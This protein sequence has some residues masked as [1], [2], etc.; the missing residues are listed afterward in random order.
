MPSMFEQQGENVLEW[1]QR[2]ND[3]KGQ[4]GCH[5]ENDWVGESSVHTE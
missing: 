1:G 2:D 5:A 4:T 3:W